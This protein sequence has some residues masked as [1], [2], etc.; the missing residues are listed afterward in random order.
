MLYFTSLHFTLA[1]AAAVDALYFI[2]DDDTN[3][4][5]FFALLCLLLFCLFLFIFAL[6]CACVRSCVCG[7]AVLC[8]ISSSGLKVFASSFSAYSS[9]DAILFNSRTLCRNRLS[10]VLSFC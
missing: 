4:Q 5:L 9:I 7:S 6:S 8:A 3:E 1:A 2:R 10:F